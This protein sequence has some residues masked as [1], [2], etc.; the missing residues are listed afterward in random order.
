MRT[1]L[2]IMSIF[3]VLSCHKSEDLSDQDIMPYGDGSRTKVDGRVFEYGSNKPLVYCMVILQEEFHEPFSGG[4]IYY[5]IDTTYTDSIGYYVFDFKHMKKDQVYSYS[6]VVE[7]IQPLYFS[8]GNSMEE[9]FWNKNRD[10][11]LD[12][13]AWIK[14]HI[15]NVNPFD[16]NDKM[17][18]SG[19]WGGGGNN[20]YHLGVKIDTFEI[21]R[22]R[23]NRNEFVCGHWW[24]NKIYSIKCDSIFFIGFDTIPYEILY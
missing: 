18:T 24:K 14:V 17:A 7:A 20:Q 1:V 12:P 11:I 10:I 15:K 21:R 23:G 8:G 2:F 19:P 22:A 9:G 6:Y 4:G 5:T 16:E 3:M 13:Y